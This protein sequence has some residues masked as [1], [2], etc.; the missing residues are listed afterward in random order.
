MKIIKKKSWLA[1]LELVLSGKK[2]FEIHVADF[3]IKKDN[4]LALEE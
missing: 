3:D 1:D 2:N 4:T